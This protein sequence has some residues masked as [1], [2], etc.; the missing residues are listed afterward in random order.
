MNS[1]YVVSRCYRAPELIFCIKNYSTEID[2]WGKNNSNIIYCSCRVHNQRDNFAE[3]IFSRC[4]RRGLIIR[5]NE[6]AWVPFGRGL[7]M[8]GKARAL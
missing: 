1:P 8:V 2:I 5:D 3:G 4:E 7:R 6:N